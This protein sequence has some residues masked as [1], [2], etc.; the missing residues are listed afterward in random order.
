MKKLLSVILAIILTVSSIPLIRVQ[1]SAQNDTAENVSIWS[2]DCSLV[3][4]TFFSAGEGTAVNPYIIKNGEQL[5][6]M[7][8]DGGKVNDEP[9]YYKLDCDIYLNDITDYDKWGTDGFDM[10]ALNNWVADEDAIY[11]KAFVGN[12]DGDGHCVYGLYACG[13][14]IASFLPLVKFGAVVRNVSFENSYVINTSNVN[15]ADREDAGETNGQKVWYAGVYGAAGVISGRCEAGD[16]DYDT[17]DFTV[18][19]CSVRYAYVQAAYFTSAIV[20]SANTCQPYVSDC[21]VAD[22]T[23]NSTNA[24]R[25]VEGAIL[26]MPYGST[27]ETSKLEN[28]LAVGLQVYGAGRDEMWSGKKI[29]SVSHTY[30][31]NNV[32]STVSH[33]YSIQHSSYGS[34]SYTDSEVEIVSESAIKG[35]TA[36]STL[37]EFDWEFIWLAVEGDY[38]TVRREY[39]VPTGDEYYANG[40]PKYTTDLWDGTVSTHFA[41]G[42]GSIGDPYLISN[43]EQFYLM[44]TAPQSAKYY[45]IADGVTDLYF[46]DV[47]GKSYTTI[48]RYFS[49]GI[50]NVYNSDAGVAFNGNFDGNGVTFHGIFAKSATR[51]GLFAQVGSATIKNFTIKN[52]Y[53]RTTSSTAE[54]AAAVVGDVA[55]NSNVY[56]RNI[57]VVDCNIQSK[58]NT[59]GLIGCA[60]KNS[61]IYIE[62]TIV[63]G[64]S[65]QS[66]ASSSYEGAFVANDISDSFIVVKNSISIG[67]YPSST[68]ETSYSAIYKNVYTDTSAPSQTV[69][70]ATEAVN[71]VENSSLM[72]DKAKATCVEFDWENLWYTTSGIPMPKK[73]ISS[74]GIGWSGD[75]AAEF[76][77]GNGTVNNPYQINNAEMLAR[78]LVYG[79]IG[80]H[81]VLTADI[82]INDTTVS[83][84]QDNAIKWYTSDDV[85]EFEGYFNGA[86]YT[87]Y[88]LYNTNVRAG[89]YSALIPVLGSDA[90]IRNVRIDNAYL[91][92]N[93]GAYLGGIV[94]IAKDNASLISSLRACDVGENVCFDG[95]ANAGGIIAKVGFTRI[96]MDNSIFKG[97]ISATGNVGGIVSEVTG[98]LEV[99]ECISAGAFPFAF[100]ENI[101]AQYIYTTESGSMSGIVTLDVNSMKGSNAKTYM[102]G[103]DFTSC[104]QTVTDAFPIPTGNAKSFNGVQGETWSGEIAISFAGGNGSEESPYLIATGEQLAL[105]ISTKYSYSTAHFKLMCDIYLNDVSHKLWESK[106]GCRNWIH[107]SNAGVF[108]GTFDGDGYVVFGMCYNYAVT[109]KNSYL[110]LFPRVGGSAVIKNVGVSQAYIKAAIGDESVYAGGLFGMGSAFYDFYGNNIRPDATVNDEFLVPGE[111][112]PRKL[113]SFTNCFVDHTC[114]IEANAVGGIGCPGGAAI[115]IRDCY[116]TATLVGKTESYTGGLIGNQWSM[117]SRVYNSLSLTQNDVKCVVG[118]HQWVGNEASICYALENLYYYGTKPIFDATRIKRPQ[119]RVGEDA[120]TAM[121]NLDWQNTWRV[122]EDGTPVLIVFDKADRNARLFS[123]KTFVVPDVKISF[124]TGVAGLTVDD[125]VGK[126]YETVDLPTP[127]RQGY[128][129]VAWHAYDDLT[130]EYP[131]DYFLPRDITLYA[132]WKDMTITQDFEDY[133]FTMWDCDDTVWNYNRPE[134]QQYD[135]DFIYEGDSSMQLLA[136]QDDIATL[137]LNY[138]DTLTEGQKYTISLRVASDSATAQPQIAIAHKMYPDYMAADKLIELVETADATDSGEWAQYTYTFTA[139][140]PWIAIKVLSSDNI[141]FDD[142]VIVPYGDLITEAVIADGVCEI[143]EGEFYASQLDCVTLSNDVTYIGEFAFAYSEFLKDVVISDNVTEIGEYAFYDS[144][145]LANVWYAGS[146]EDFKNIV[147]CENNQPLLDAVW[148]FDSC[149]V[150]Q[151]HSYSDV[152]DSECNNCG[153]TRVTDV[154]PGDVNCD[155]NINNRDYALLM[156]YINKWDV[157]IVEEAAD[158]NADGN[159]NNRDYALLM[160]YINKWDVILK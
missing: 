56:L 105:A 89:E 128:K 45:K 23:L 88:G 139:T 131:Y 103:L 36:E 108:A 109:P 159:I 136:G 133:P 7:I 42:D 153:Y 52:S 155:G 14:R 48:M 112:T 146:K 76:A 16:D 68:A 92:G 2:G 126:P 158:V 79:K 96:K 142:I 49:L 21:V 129:F 46:N 148:H 26:N 95:Q 101:D 87:V 82:Y 81:F 152:G 61:D 33:T 39:V 66:S 17:V 157:T 63:S 84:W 12:F 40:G 54:G 125:L 107:S 116:V 43:C 47:D 72:G 100:D 134:S 62:N 94:G 127:V 97:K 35:L 138:T 147:I 150:G 86:G 110:G 145:R 69:A 5:Y 93:E 154:K 53:I 70:D 149:G 156:Q 114:Y 15:S 24:T 22:V 98:E 9:A 144:S 141:Y 58:T 38:P 135:A 124:D 74:D 57:A 104:W 90:H 99:E 6:R 44:V 137:L 75:I 18:K 106:A 20:A 130:L 50:G 37:S 120:K 111:T 80:E 27:D 132:E 41:A 11:N 85:Y 60:H 30:Q 140:T 67:I 1:V 29:P 31:F 119:W 143:Y 13:Y 113:P 34:L 121:P 151:S 59:A 83:E 19:N 102:S 55:E 25:G 73:Y 65:I 3:R 160:Q 123:D 10:S 118:S 91:S 28:I 77:G 51:S 115:V 78:M 122:E 71:V 32:Y 4:G 8:Y 117:G 64:G